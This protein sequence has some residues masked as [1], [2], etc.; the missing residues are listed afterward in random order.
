MTFSKRMGFGI[1]GFGCGALGSVA[2]ILALSSRPALAEY[3]VTTLQTLLERTQIE[4]LIVDYYA[5]LG[6]G[7][8]HDFGSFFLDDGVLDV[9]GSVSQGKKAISELYDKLEQ[10]PALPRGTFHMLITNPKIVVDGESA[11]ADVL[12][13]GIINDTITGPPRFVEQGREH[14]ELVKRNGRWY[15]KHRV[16]T[17]DSGLPAMFEKTYKQR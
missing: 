12:W 5:L 4:D 9:N 10:H 1:K 11:T 8:Q 2:L 17:A 15:F 3:P 6:G 7:H 16:I 14:D 13:T